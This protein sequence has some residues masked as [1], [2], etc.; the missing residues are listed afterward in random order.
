[1][2]PRRSAEG[3]V[4]KPLAP[5]EETKDPAEVKVW[6]RPRS[7]R[8]A[9]RRTGYSVPLNPSEFRGADTL[10]IPLHRRARP[11]VPEYNVP[12]PGLLNNKK[13]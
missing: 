10:M 9:G 6:S 4:M 11:S 8:S 7:G 3:N 2:D 1:M 5:E 12:L 13:P